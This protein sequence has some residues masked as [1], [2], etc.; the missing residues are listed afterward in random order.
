MI[1]LIIY[2]VLLHVLS[3]EKMKGRRVHCLRKDN[4]QMFWNI[5]FI[6]M[7]VLVHFLCGFQ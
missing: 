5:P 4:S 1:Q 3:T 6:D 7:N 2:V